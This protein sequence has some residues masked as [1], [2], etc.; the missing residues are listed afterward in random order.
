MIYLTGDC[1]GDFGRFSRKQRT[2]MPFEITENDFVILCGDMGLL[3]ARDREFHVNL[4]LDERH[5]VLYK[6][7]IALE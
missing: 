3:W 7:I 6:D 2:Q 5:T 1:H 4:R